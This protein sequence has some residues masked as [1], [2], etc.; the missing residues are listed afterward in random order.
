MIT[1]IPAELKNAAIQ[2]LQF[3]VHS[4]RPLK[5]AE[6][7]EAIATQIENESQGFDINNQPF[8][9][10]DVLYYCSG[11]IKIVHAANKELHLAHFS[12]KE[13][14]LG[15]NDFTFTKAAAESIG[16]AVGNLTN[17]YESATT[18]PSGPSA[19]DKKI[20]ELNM[21]RPLSTNQP[22]DLE[23]D[24]GY[25]SAS[26]PAT[27]AIPL[28]TASRGREGKLT[29]EYFD[30][31][32]SIVSDDDDVGSQASDETT[33]E[34]KIGKAL[35]GIFLAEEPNF[36]PLCAKAMARMSRQRFV[37]NLRRL[38]KSFYRN[39]VMEAESVN[40][41]SVAKLL[42]SRRGRLRIS[43]QV[44]DHI[45]SSQEE[46]IRVDRNSPLVRREEKHG[47]ETWLAHTSDEP[48]DLQWVEREI[49][50]DGLSESDS[51]DDLQ[52]GFPYID[53]LTAFLK[54]ARSFE[55]LLRDFTLMFLPNAIRLVLLGI[56]KRH[57][58]ISRK[59]DITVMNTLKAWVEDSTQVRWNWWPLE[60]R[61][62]WLRHGESRLYWQCVG[63]SF[64]GSYILLMFFRHVVP[65]NGK[66]YRPNNLN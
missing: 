56:P 44:A 19:I 10:T 43:H 5:L 13:Y 3:L 32:Q 27:S 25:V 15:E 14:L 23:R 16:S 40:Q 53:E 28:E 45:Q 62:R 48:T 2:L 8:C 36:R 64:T 7:M 39:L 11:L 4:Q 52:A 47:V 57:I 38:L 26:R 31:L 21:A 35:L 9:G 22:D 61:K 33:S 20:S 66:K 24:S 30:E 18:F 65:S 54:T 29:T 12:V 49:V 51:N 55:I 6:A 63:A 46:T 60:P 59:Q 37:E 34:G 1:N 42:R 50:D 17:V 58:R 41:N